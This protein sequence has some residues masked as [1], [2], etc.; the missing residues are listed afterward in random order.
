MVLELL[1][2]NKK[3]GTFFLDSASAGVFSHPR[4]VQNIV[5]LSVCVEATRSCAQLVTFTV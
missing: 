1:T 3:F 5:V 4:P 2:L